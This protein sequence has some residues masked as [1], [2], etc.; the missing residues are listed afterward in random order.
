MRNDILTSFAGIALVFVFVLGMET[1]ASL[2]GRGGGGQGM[3]RPGGGPG[4]SGVPGDRSAAR[5][6][7]G[8]ANG[9]YNAPPDNANG[10]PRRGH[11]NGNG[12]SNGTRDNTNLTPRFEALYTRLGYSSASALQ[13]AYEASGVKFGQFVAARVISNNLSATH[14]T[15]TS[16]AIISGIKSG[17]TLIQTLEDLGLT[18]SE[19]RAAERDARKALKP[20][21]QQ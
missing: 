18:E 10:R 3:G 4:S 17:K 7:R 14:P 13:T 2:Q 5:P 11:D 20:P 19:A 16:D 6:D 9:N 21:K 15:V 12:N 8:N 1:V